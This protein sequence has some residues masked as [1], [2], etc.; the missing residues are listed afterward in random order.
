MCRLS[1]V[2]TATAHKSA[3]EQGGNKD[4]HDISSSSFIV[5]SCLCETKE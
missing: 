2:D 1:L 3:I 4:C 5:Y